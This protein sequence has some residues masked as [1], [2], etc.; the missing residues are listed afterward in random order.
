MV[1]DSCA[2][3]GAHLALLAID[4]VV[5]MPCFVKTTRYPS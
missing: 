4:A 2:S 1:A 3:G 5:G